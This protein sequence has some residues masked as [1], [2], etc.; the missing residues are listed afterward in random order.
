MLVL[1]LVFN[2]WMKSQ[3]L[4][5]NLHWTLISVLT[6]PIFI[7]FWLKFLQGL[8]SA[9]ALFLFQLILT[10]II[11][12]FE[13]SAACGENKFTLHLLEFLLSD[14]YFAWEFCILISTEGK[15]KFSLHCTEFQLLTFYVYS[16]VL[17]KYQQI[18]V[19]AIS[20][21][22]RLILS[23]WQALFPSIWG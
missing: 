13:K 16:F 17:L 1:G 15:F 5:V 9:S 21:C 20:P 23:N 4:D 10:C 11:R 3:Q 6:F 2:L 19:N 12:T 14:M 8:V 22:T 18:E 7:N